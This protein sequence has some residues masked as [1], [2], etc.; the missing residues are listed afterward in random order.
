[1]ASVFAV[2]SKKVFETQARSAGKVLTLGGVWATSKYASTHAALKP[3]ADGGHLFLVTVRPPNE[4]LW[5]IAVLRDVKAAKG[6]WSATTNT[7][8][9]TDVSP[10][11]TKIRFA[12]GAGIT[13]PKGKLGMSL[14]MPRTLTDADVQLLL[15]VGTG[16][17]GAAPPTV[18][19][20]GKIYHLNRHDKGPLPCLCVKCLPNAGERVVVDG[21]AFVRREAHA[22][23]RV[24]YY[25]MPEVLIPTEKAVRFDVERRMRH[26]LPE[27]IVH[28][29]AS[30]GSGDEDEDE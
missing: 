11:K 5:L 18:P 7:T 3:L 15:S 27:A 6:G 10:L 4:A 22:K 8:P 25:W 20:T 17:A 23:S 9:I 16:A 19:T 30:R 1:V 13:A 14:Q 21:E 26:R 29:G 2:V 12:S 24:L 28:S